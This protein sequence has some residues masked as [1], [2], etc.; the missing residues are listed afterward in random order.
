MKQA[1]PSS[2]YMRTSIFG[3]SLFFYSIIF[4][5]NFQR[6][7]MHIHFALLDFQLMSCFSETKRRCN[8]RATF[9]GRLMK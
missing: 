5:V 4:F 3:I 8:C 1:V 2:L 6:I 9:G 7:Y